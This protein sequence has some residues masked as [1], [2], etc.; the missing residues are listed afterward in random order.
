MVP[1][2]VEDRRITF[3]WSESPAEPTALGH[4]PPHLDAASTWSRPRGDCSPW[5]L[6][7]LVPPSPRPDSWEPPRTCH[8][9]SRSYTFPPFFDHS[10]TPKPSSINPFVR[11]SRSLSNE[12]RL[13]TLVRPPGKTARSRGARPPC[14]PAVM[15][16]EYTGAIWRAGQHS[17][18]VRNDTRWPSLLAPPSTARRAST[19]ASAVTVR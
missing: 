2:S 14:G 4:Q 13:G 15:L 7:R 16:S 11:F 1:A 9:P 10:V 18:P 3:T 19:E 8:R 12:R 6:P 17:R 5:R